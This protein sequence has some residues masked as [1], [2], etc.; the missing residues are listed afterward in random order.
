MKEGTGAN[1]CREGRRNMKQCATFPFD[2]RFLVISIAVILVSACST[3]PPPEEAKDVAS[4]RGRW[5]GW[6][7]VSPLGP[8]YIKLSVREGGK[9]E[10]TTRPDFSSYGNQFTGRVMVE[11]GKFAFDTDTPGL[12]GTSTLYYKEGK[13]FMLF[14]SNDANTKAELMRVY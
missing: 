2:W 14:I 11:E 10:M 3:L 13:R 9:W 6:G 8:I 7:S 5:E 1:V 12:S 4:I